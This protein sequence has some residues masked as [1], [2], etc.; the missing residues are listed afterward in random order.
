MA[1]LSSYYQLDGFLQT[2]TRVF[3][4]LFSGCNKTLT[5]VS[6]TLQSP[7]Y[8]RKYPDGQYCSWKIIV[9][10]THQIHLVFTSFR[11]QDEKNTDELYVYDGEDETGEVLGLF[12]GGHPPPKEG[13]FSSSNRM[14]IIFKSDKTY[15]YT[16]FSA[17]Y[18]ADKR[19]SK[20]C[21]LR[22]H[23]PLITFN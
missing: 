22:D 21:W 19:P 8:P 6:D 14:F 18:Y 7:N 10:T 2:T 13:I 3:F 12:Y 11:L 5:A 23:C 4:F 16:G 17:S 1:S 9:S 15:S 20:S